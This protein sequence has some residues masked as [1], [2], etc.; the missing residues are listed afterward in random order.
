MLRYAHTFLQHYLNCGKFQVSSVSDSLEGV[1]EILPLNRYIIG[2]DKCTSNPRGVW[3]RNLRN[4]AGEVTFCRC[5]YFLGE[6]LTAVWRL[7]LVVNVTKHWKELRKVWLII[8]LT[9]IQCMRWA[10]DA[11]DTGECFIWLQERYC[12]G[13]EGTVSCGK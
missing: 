6:N 1:V 2:W 10:S 7:L 11:G 9:L 3:W 12:G 8:L 13:I 4:A 5:S